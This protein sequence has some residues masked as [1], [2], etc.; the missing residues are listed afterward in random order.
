MT[1]TGRPFV[2]SIQDGTLDK[3]SGKVKLMPLKVYFDTIPKRKPNNAEQPLA[4]KSASG[5]QLRALIEKHQSKHEP[6]SF[7]SI[8][9]AKDGDNTFVFRTT[10][11]TLI[12]T[13][14][15]AKAARD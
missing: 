4:I 9:S 14:A 3:D 8:S 13:A 5:G 7:F 10:K 2:V 15:G 6:L 11:S 12:A 1:R